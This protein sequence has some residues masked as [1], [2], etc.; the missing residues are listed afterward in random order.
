MGA[1]TFDFGLFGCTA[2]DKEIGRRG[3]EGG[4]CTHHLGVYGYKE[5][6]IKRAVDD[7]VKVGAASP[8]IRLCG[9]K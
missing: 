2:K 6:R 4:F 9:Y 8:D 7:K 5:T 1:A 3:R